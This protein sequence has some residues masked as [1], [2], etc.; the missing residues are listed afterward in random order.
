MTSI[1]DQH[2]SIGVESTYGTAVAPTRAY[3]AR[4][5]DWQR[6]VEF[7]ESGGFRADRQTVRSDR[8]RTV[9]L[10]ATGSIETTVF[11]RGMGLLLQHVLGTTVSPAQQG[12]TAAYLTTFSSDD[13]GPQKSYTVVVARDDFGTLQT[14]QYSGCVATGFSLEA[15]IG[16][17]LMLTVN[18]DAAAETVRSAVTPVYAA[19]S[20]P[21]VW[22]D[23]TL[24]V[25]GAEARYQSFSLDADLAM[26]TD[27]RYLKG[28][29]T[30]AQ[31][32]RSG[33]PAYSGT[34]EGLGVD[35]ADYDRFV[36]GTVF[37][38]LFTAKLAAA[39]EGTHYPQF[40]VTLPACKFTG[41]TPQASVDDVAAISL[42]YVALHDGTDAAAKIEITSVDTAL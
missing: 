13:T 10:G 38:I 32:V 21:F 11:D 7:V 4:S 23:C 40:K 17:P 39:I 31:P 22:E 19:A 20:V 25:A 33:V 15:S 35:K 27:L 9:S 42:P 16:D 3:E 18:Y 29:A 28:A 1:L 26:R 34:I 2:V 8:H 5:D 12:A 6:E 24:T 41:S 37:E 30:K 14:F 36:A